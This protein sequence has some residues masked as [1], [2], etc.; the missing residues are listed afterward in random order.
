MNLCTAR[1]VWQ[2]VSARQVSLWLHVL[3]CLLQLAHT[4][5]WLWDMAAV[6]VRDARRLRC[7][8]RKLATAHTEC[9]S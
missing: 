4:V 3:H 5:V 1:G 8:G 2:R 9:T 6:I 7:S